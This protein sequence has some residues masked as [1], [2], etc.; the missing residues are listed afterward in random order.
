MRAYP[1]LASALAGFAAGAVTGLFGAGGGMVLVPLLAMLTDLD[2]REIFPACAKFAGEMGR[3]VRDIREAGV[4]PIAEMR[5]LKLVTER[6]VKLFDAIN[7]LR[8][9]ILNTKQSSLALENAQYERYIIVPAMAK[10]REIADDLEALVGK[11][12]WPFPTYDDLLFNV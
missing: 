10:V 3:I 6:N 12:Y 8:D 1:R 11:E 2:E 4:E 9:A 5:L 7:S